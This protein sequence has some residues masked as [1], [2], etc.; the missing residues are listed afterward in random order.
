MI[1]LNKQLCEELD[2]TYWQLNEEDSLQTYHTINREER[3]LLRKI[4]LAKGITL[5]DEIM[6]IQDQGV[7]IVSV[8]NHKLVFDDVK[9]QD[10]PNMT[11]LAKI[12]DMLVSVEHKKHTWHKLKNID[13]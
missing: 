9:V 7:V 4:L 1:E 12:S 3:E 6:D 13:L 11:H 10:T 5:S 8:Q 2:I